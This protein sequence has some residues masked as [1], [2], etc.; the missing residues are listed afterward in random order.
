MITDKKIKRLFAMMVVFALFILLIPGP[1]AAAEKKKMQKITI[2]HASAALHWYPSYVADAAGFFAAE[3][4]DVEWINVGAG[5]KQVAAVAGGSAT[6]TAVGM[7][8]AITATQNGGKLVAFAALFNRYPL[9]LVLSNQALQK[10]GIS[11]AM[12]IDEK[13][14]RLKD[15]TVAVTGVGSSTD[16]I[17][18]SWLLARN[19][20]PDKVLHIQPVGN[21]PAIMAAF[22]KNRV[23]GFVLSAPFPEIVESR[24]IG[25]TVID[26]LTDNIP[27][28]E[29]VPYAAMIT[30][31]EMIK[32]NP[33][34]IMATTRAL[35]RAIKFTRENPDKVHELL[36]KFFPKVDPALY[37]KFEPDYRVASAKTPIIT[38]AQYNRLINWMKITSDEQITVAY[39]DMIAVNF[40]ETAAKE[41]LNQ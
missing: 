21:P 31:R 38:R 13:V 23:D 36:K 17:I 14:K 18:R 33:D 37:A 39:E 24:G 12:T 27:E 40:A 16:T 11:K 26:P 22:E 25:A 19:F 9:Q 20:D 4:L 41:I 1:L 34:L 30:T 3:G 28:L 5:S 6:M 32:N 8:P 29:D 15:I 35:T 10:T 2:A 7:Q